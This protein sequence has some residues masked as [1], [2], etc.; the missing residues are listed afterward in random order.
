MRS[1]SLQMVDGRFVGGDALVAKARE[2]GR[3]DYDAPFEGVQAIDRY[4]LQFKLVFAD[5]ELLS[6]LTTSALS[7]VAREVIDAYRD[8]NGWAMANPVGTG[9]FRLKDWRRGQRIVLEAN[10][11][12]RDERYPAPIDADDRKVARLTGR[13]LPLVRAV[14]S[15]SSRKAAASSRSAKGA[16][17]AGRAVEP[18]T[19]VLDA[20]IARTPPLRRRRA[21]RARCTARDRVHILQHGRSVTAATHRRTSHCAAIVMGYDVRE[22][23]RVAQGSLP[24]TQ[25]PPNMTGHDPS[26]DG[27]VKYDVRAPRRCS[28]SSATSIATATDSA[29]RPTASRSC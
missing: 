9:P 20:T 7:A 2:T 26:Y 12:Y 8:D 17:L 6:N 14:E 22:E 5:Y 1:N 10:P 21:A 18:G 15:A 28:T 25:S 4:T 13:K 24:A 16:R 3:F 19:K 23:I 27:R 29:T 11:G